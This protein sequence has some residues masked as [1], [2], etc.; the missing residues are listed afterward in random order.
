M[1]NVM[2]KFSPSQLKIRFNGTFGGIPSRS[3]LLIARI[4]GGASPEAR[5][6][7]WTVGIKQT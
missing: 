3:D 2:S 5:L 6:F 1:L 4:I 7:M